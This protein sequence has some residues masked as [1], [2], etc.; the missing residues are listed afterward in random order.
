MRFLKICLTVRVYMILFE[1]MGICVYVGAI[2]LKNAH[3]MTAMNIVFECY[4]NV[5]CIETNLR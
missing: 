3:G 4:K 5:Y 1:Y 2:I